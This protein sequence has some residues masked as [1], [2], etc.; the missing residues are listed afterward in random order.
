MPFVHSCPQSISLYLVCLH[1]DF[2]IMYENRHH[3]NFEVRQECLLVVFFLPVVNGLLI[4]LCDGNV[5][6]TGIICLQ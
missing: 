3:A 4:F 6:M 1:Q 5:L 2:L